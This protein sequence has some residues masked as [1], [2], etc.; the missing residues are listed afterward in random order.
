[1]KILLTGGC[2]YIGTNLTNAL[3]KEGHEVTVVDIMW[4]GN[5]L[6]NHDNLTIIQADIREIDKIPMK[7]IDTVL[8]L[9]NIANDPTGD[10]NSKL[11]WEVNALAS[12]FLIEKA[13]CNN[14]KQFIFASSGTFDK[15]VGA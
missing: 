5:H 2:G 7:N 15:T 12:K 1:M 8:H 10:L 3:L 11:T 9:A 14:V 4:F 6:E 13:I